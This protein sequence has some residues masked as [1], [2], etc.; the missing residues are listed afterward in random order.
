MLLSSF[1]LQF[2]RNHKT[3][4]QC[5]IITFLHNCRICTGTVRT[6][7]WWGNFG[8]REGEN[9]F[10][11]WFGYCMRRPMPR[12]LRTFQPRAVSA[13]HLTLLCVIILADFV[14][15]L[16]NFL[17]R[18]LPATH[19]YGLAN[20]ILL[21]LLNKNNALNSGIKPQNFLYWWIYIWV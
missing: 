16:L 14:K 1:I 7:R 11:I 21:T 8:M 9:H 6:Y 20:K 12:Y 15:T 3:Y 10:I 13:P 17:K 19:F 18:K 5:Q 2:F 4:V